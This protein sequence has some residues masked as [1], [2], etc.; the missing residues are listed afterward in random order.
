MS[1]RSLKLYSVIFTLPTRTML[2]KIPKEELTTDQKAFNVGKCVKKMDLY[3]FSRE[4]KRFNEIDWQ[5]YQ[6]V[7]IW[8]D[9]ETFICLSQKG[10]VRFSPVDT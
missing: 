2:K 9:N 3:Q 1:E 6:G 10:P 5:N 4:P 7:A 8:R